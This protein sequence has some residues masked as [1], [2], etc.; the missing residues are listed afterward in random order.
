MSTWT[1][2]TDRPGWMFRP[3]AGLFLLLALSGCLGEG[4][5]NAP[6]FLTSK[7][8]EAGEAFPANAK[9]KARKPLVR[10]KLA[11][12]RVVV[13]G[14]GGYC[15]DPNTLSVRATGGF[16]LLAACG[17]LGAEDSPYAEPA[18]MTVQVQPRLLKQDVP[19][20]AAMTAALA[21]ARV[22]RH[23]DGDGVSLVQVAE[24][25]DK[26]LPGGDPKHWRGAMV[27]NG[28]LVGMA[29]YAPEGSPMADWA[30]HELILALAEALREA[31][32]VKDYSAE[33]AAL[34][35]PAGSDKA[36]GNKPPNKGLGKLFPKLFQ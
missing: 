2:D 22:L 4:A 25:G 14:P 30:G 34:K 7:S 3:A 17:A 9:A 15:I 1:C 10:A 18:L 36:T 12:G 5:G 8:A 24:G 31:S 32:P 11:G 33:A 13:A 19:N 20:A 16:A 23:E 21:P 29:I 35:A 6:G 28:Y 27:I 26:G